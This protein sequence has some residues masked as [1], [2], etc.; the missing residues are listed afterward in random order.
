MQI[1]EQA[2]QQR[3]HGFQ[4][5][6]SGNP[7][8]RLSN[9]ERQRRIEAQARELAVEFGG[10]EVLSPVDRVLLMQAAA[11]LLRRPKSA[12]DIVRVANSVQRLLGGLSKRKRREPAVP[13][14]ADYVAR[15]TSEGKAGA[16]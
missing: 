9:A 14:V 4:P 5:G 3:S 16:A 13:S 15:L 6:Q 8:G 10:F 1:P 12:E 7:G 2:S 11:L